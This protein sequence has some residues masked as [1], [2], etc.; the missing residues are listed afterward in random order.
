[1]LEPTVLYPNLARSVSPEL[2]SHVIETPLLP[3]DPETLIP[4]PTGIRDS[5][6][7]VVNNFDFGSVMRGSGN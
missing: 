7:R 1:L 2:D 3:A 4:M 5:L 6:A